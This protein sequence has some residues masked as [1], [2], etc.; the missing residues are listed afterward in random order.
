M[1]G[2]KGDNMGYVYV[3]PSVVEY[4]E[5]FKELGSLDFKIIRAMYRYGVR[6]ISQ[7][8][9]LIGVPQQTVSYRVKRFDERDLVRFRALISEEKL[10]L[11][12][13]LVVASTSL[14][15]EELSS[16]SMTCFPL[17]RYLA[18]V[19]G[20]K[21]GNYVRYIIPPDKETDLKA[22]LDKLKDTGLILRYELYETTSPYYPLL[23]LDFYTGREGAPVFN[24]DKWIDDFDSFSE[25]KISEPSF[26]KAKFDL[27][28]LIIL[29][30]LEINARMKFREVARE[31]AK[32]LREENY[33]R[34]IPLVSRRFKNIVSQ[35]LIRGYR[36]VVFPNLGPTVL[37]LIYYLKFTSAS[38]LGRFLGG[39]SYLPYNFSYLKVLGKNEIFLH[40]VIPVYEYLN[41]RKA[42]SRLGE[43]GYLKSAYVLIGDLSQAWD[44]VKIYEMYKDGAWNFSYGVVLKMLKEALARRNVNLEI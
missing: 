13:Y 34:F 21:H 28:D 12:S 25:E 39:L 14:G 20:W 18:I 8:A 9:K 3:I 11:K 43:L 36:V 16:Y 29:R 4:A 15:M 23:N 6:N 27:Y 7:I 24:W 37:F 10:G 17:W 42:I 30:C 32:I 35:N 40:L 44:N 31:I 38:N 33:G 41:L 19:D 26:A 2:I 22:F 1:S 5:K